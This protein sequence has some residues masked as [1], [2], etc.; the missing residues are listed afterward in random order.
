MTL[1]TKR[2]EPNIYWTNTNDA[3]ST[4]NITTKLALFPFFNFIK[5]NHRCI[6]VNHENFWD[7]HIAQGE[8]NSIL[9]T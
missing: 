4:F 8:N 6:Y 3:I 9:L 7:F 2:K 5:F 1:I